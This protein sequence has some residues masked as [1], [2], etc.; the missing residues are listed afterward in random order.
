[1]S[2]SLYS[3]S[4]HL[5]LTQGFLTLFK[6]RGGISSSSESEHFA[7]QRYSQFITRFGTFP[8]LSLYFVVEVIARHCL[9]DVLDALCG[10]ASF[11]WNC[12][13]LEG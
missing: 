6:Y 3:A 8:D 10:C 9:F 1:M 12:L 2:V 7:F 13:I 11:D 5:L 4:V